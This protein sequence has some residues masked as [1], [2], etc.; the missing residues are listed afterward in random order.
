MSEKLNNADYVVVRVDGDALS[1]E[2]NKIKLKMASY[3]IIMEVQNAYIDEEITKKEEK[4]RATEVEMETSE[5]KKTITEAD[6]KMDEL[7]SELEILYNAYTKF[8]ESRTRFTEI[9]KKALRLPEENLKELAQKGHT[10]IKGQV[11]EEKEIET[12]Y[13]AA[14]NSLVDEKD[15][16][17]FS[18]IDNK[19]IQEELD[20][21]LNS[22]IKDEGTEKNGATLLAETASADYV[23]GSDELIEDA[24]ELKTK[25][26]IKKA[27][28]DSSLDFTGDDFNTL[29]NIAGEKEV[30]IDDIFSKADSV[31]ETSTEVNSSETS[32]FVTPQTEK[33]EEKPIFDSNDINLDFIDFSDDEELRE[34][35][36]NLNETRE[37]YESSK[38]VLDAKN[39]EAEKL[40]AER[41]AKKQ[42]AQDKYNQATEVRRKAREKAIT[43]KKLE[44]QRMREQL[45]STNDQIK[46]SDANITNINKEIAGYQSSIDKSEQIINGG[47]TK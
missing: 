1:G 44:L 28:K 39:R 40:S 2:S 46:E 26:D 20:R 3:A 18:S 10:E 6:K 7:E 41:E 24:K 15:N 42:E 25:I 27:T 32:D 36:R 16:N 30:N 22:T 14:Q 17:L 38:A 23:D 11:V 33:S 43:E 13:Q 19:A 21:V 5:D 9:A 34:L 8:S 31:V 37:L 35:D 47:R 12:A 29:L 45:V 4:I